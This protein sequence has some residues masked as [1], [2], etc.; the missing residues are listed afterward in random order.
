MKTKEPKTLHI[1]EKELSMLISS[2]EHYQAQIA[3][4]CK[5][6]EDINTRRYDILEGLR[7][8]LFAL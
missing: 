3:N 6:E 5:K 7:T 4:K 1:T 8:K 2:I